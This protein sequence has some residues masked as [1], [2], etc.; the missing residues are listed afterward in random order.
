VE[1]RKINIDEVI[2]AYKAGKVAEVFGTGTAAVIA[3]VKELNYK[4]YRMEFNP[5]N[6]K[7]SKHIKSWLNDIREGKAEDRYGWMVKV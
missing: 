7:I 5:D 4:G 3:P 6:Y 2:T 1:E